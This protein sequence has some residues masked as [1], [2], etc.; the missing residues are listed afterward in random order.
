MRDHR[1]SILATHNDIRLAESVVHISGIAFERLVLLG[2]EEFRIGVD[3]LMRERFV[4]HFNSAEGFLSNLLRLGGDRG[5]NL[6]DVLDIL[7]FLVAPRDFHSG[8]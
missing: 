2:V 3:D 6:A 7:E 8:H 5:D 4:L 1:N